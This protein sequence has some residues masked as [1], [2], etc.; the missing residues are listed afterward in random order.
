[1][2]LDQAK[3]AEDFFLF[4][5]LGDFEGFSLGLNSAIHESFNGMGAST[6]RFGGEAQLPLRGYAVI[7]DGCPEQRLFVGSLC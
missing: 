1:M 4:C 3:R 7:I 6:Q 2:G 5:Q